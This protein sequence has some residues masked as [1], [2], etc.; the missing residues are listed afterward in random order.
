MTS[1]K[2]SVV[3]P[4]YSME[5]YEDFRECVEGVLSQTYD[6]VEAVLIVDG[7]KRV[8][9]KALEE[10]GERDDTV[11]YCSHENAGPI[12]R[13]NM[14]AVQASG[15]IIALTDDDALPKEDWVE[16]LVN[17]YEKYDCTAAGGRVEPDWV[18]GN[19]DYIPE[20]FFFLI[21]ATYRGFQ[22]GEGEVRNTFGANLSYKRDAFLKL[23]GMKIAGLGPSSVQ[24]RE[25]EFCARLKQR[26]GEGVMYNPDAVVYHKIYNYR[27]KK[28][29]L[30]KRAFWQGYSKRGMERLMPEA[31]GNESEF[32]GKLLTEYVPS[33]L[34]KA[35]GGSTE[36]GNKLIMLLMLTMAVGFGYLYGILMWR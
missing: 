9:K 15:E 33:R 7:N 26:Y 29:W 22:E 25:T 10:F 2:V 27:T 36:D 11:V 31:T 1:M 20:E 23:G 5:R 28:K 24:G 30:I 4:T 12:S 21:G 18:A 19:P 17:M 3:I 16:E 14:G 6:D 34:R 13:A 32:L 8:C 35:V